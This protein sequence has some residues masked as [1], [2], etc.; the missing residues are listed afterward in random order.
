[1]SRRANQPDAHEA[2]NAATIPFLLSATGR[3]AAAALAS[4]DLSAVQTMPILQELRR[5]FD[6][7]A[8]GALL[9]LARLRQKAATKFP[10]AD[11]L[12]F[13]GEA[14][15]QATAWP[16]AQQRAAW[17]GERAP[18][19]PILDLGCGIGGDLLALAQ[20]RPVIGIE[21]DRVRLQLAQANVDALGLTDQVHLIEAD[22]TVLRRRHALPT[23]AAAFADPARRAAG[24]RIFSLHEIQPPVAE[25]VALQQQIPALGVKVMPGVNDAEIPADCGVEFISHEG[26]CKEAVLW[27]GPLAPL[28]RWASVRTAAGWHELAADSTPPPVGPLVVGGYL[29]E[30]D[31]AVIRAGALGALCMALG[32]HLFDE[33]IAYLAAPH[34]QSHPLVQSFRIDEIAPFSLKTLNQRLRAYGIGQVELKKRG[35]PVA[36]EELR[37]RLKLTPGG[38]AGVIIFTRRGDERLMLIGERVQ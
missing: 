33:Q 25:L 3:A 1:M 15:E 7:D 5:N 27:F 20:Q 29:H 31:P 37:P 9:A 22:W 13:T 26:I 24:R 10:A 8:A 17:L 6:A 35:F 34:Y 23:A 14:L 38:R 12:F 32:A 16:I 18:A 30:P 4:A 2:I 28:P 19:G 36:P 11:Q 21:Q